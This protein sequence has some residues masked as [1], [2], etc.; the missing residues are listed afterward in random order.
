MLLARKARLLAA[1]NHL[2]IFLD[3]NPNSEL[4]WRELKRLFELPGSSWRDFASEKISEGGGVFD[5]A[6]RAVPLTPQVRAMLGVEDEVLSGEELIRAILRM[7]VD[8]LWNGGIGTYIKAS[9]ESNADVGD[10]TNAAVRIDA[11]ELRTRVVGEGGNL[12][13]TQLARV[14]YTLA[15]GRINTDAIDNSGGVDL[16]D[17]EVNF[18]ILLA[19]RCRDGRMSRDERNAKLRGCLREAGAAV[20]AHNAAQSRCISMDL[21]RS[22]EDPERMILVTEF[23]EQHADLDPALEFLP[24]KEE[25]HA[26]ASLP[27]APIGSTRPELAILLGYTKMLAK[28]ELVSSDVL[29]HPCLRAVLRAYLPESLR[30]VLAEDIDTHPLRREITAT[31]LANRVIDQGGV[32]LVPELVRATGASVAEVLLACYIADRSLEA[33]RL[34]SALEAQPV[35]EAVRL[36]AALRIEEAVREAAYSCLAPQRSR[37]DDDDEFAEWTEQVRAL[38]VLVDEGL[39]EASEAHIE[40]HAEVLVEGLLEP[41]LA[42]EIDRLPGFAQALGAVSLAMRWNAPLARVVQLHATMG[43]ATR[44]SWLLQRL[45]DMGRDDDWD[46]LAS[47]ALHVEMLEAQRSLT[48]RLLTEPDG[49]DALSEF[50]AAHARGLEQIERTV[51]QIEAG[52][53]CGLAPLTVLSQQIRR[54]C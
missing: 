36:G 19:P 28:R 33:D 31:C 25:L 53:R 17:H 7:P 22:Q 9:R 32:T 15:G 4:V 2:H 43:E 6:A 35:S 8:L 11:S 13:L 41:G 10:R 47:D 14:E 40:I 52:E 29:D 51:Q 23:L 39:E 16:S 21:L 44:I 12:G 3:P 49:T 20:L 26:R 5:R 34:R 24:E 1:F 30:Q 42:R 38:R 37:W 46:R 48:G 18:K 45:H 50:S 27:G 54:L